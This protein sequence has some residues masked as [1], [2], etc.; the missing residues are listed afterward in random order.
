MTRSTVPVLALAAGLLAVPAAPALAT[1]GGFTA[2][3]D[4]G[5]GG[6]PSY[7]FGVPATGPS[8]EIAVLA[9][10]TR[11]H[12][13]ASTVLLRRTDR[14]GRLGTPLVLSRSSFGSSEPALSVRSDGDVLAAWLAYV[15]GSTARSGNRRVRAARVAR[16]TRSGS[17]D[18]RSLTGGG[19][20][21]Y[22]PT[23]LLPGTPGPLLTWARRTGPL[24]SARWT[25]RAGIDVGASAIPLQGVQLSIPAAGNVNGRIVAAVGTRA[26]RVAV[27]ADAG[28]SFGT[29]V[30][31]PGSLDVLGTPSVSVDREGLGAVAW[32]DRSALD[33]PMRIPATVVGPQASAPARAV[34]LE[35]P[36]SAPA[37][38]LVAAQRD[39][40]LV[41]WTVTARKAALADNSPGVMRLARIGADG[42]GRGA[43]VPLGGPGERGRV[44]G[45]V[46]RAGDRAQAFW[47][48]SSRALRAQ[49]IGATGRPGRAV[50][51]DR[52]IDTASVRVAGSGTSATAVTWTARGRLR[53]ASKPR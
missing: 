45:L 19:S 40:A 22:S 14:R 38:P 48:T 52:G 2:P 13:R 11:A 7:G 37:P 16:G 8:G 34:V 28:R 9:V 35:Q 3:V 24:Q 4:V 1:G 41:A 33:G 27:S 50:T 43:P 39:G 21:A 12:S 31:V 47:V 20:S 15:P 29:G 25:S 36:A 5:P 32:A 17:V 6:A 23:F 26:L 10:R 53:L 51:L 46:P 30:P 49:V 44:V 42:S 18:V